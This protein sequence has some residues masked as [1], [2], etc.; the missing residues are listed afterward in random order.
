MGIKQ[1]LST[2]QSPWQ[3]A[4]VERVIGTIRR[5]CQDHVI[6]FND[7]CLHRHLG[8]FVDYCHKTRTHLSLERDSPEPRPIQP[9][10]S[11]HIIAIPVLGGLH[12]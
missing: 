6:V 4:Y 2:P 5:E 1:V 12:H 11:G 9:P 8:R 10:T 7:R 3:R